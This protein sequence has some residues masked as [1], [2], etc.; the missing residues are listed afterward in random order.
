MKH[1]E[2]LKSFRESLILADSDFGLALVEFCAENDLTDFP[3]GG[4]GQGVAVEDGTVLFRYDMAYDGE[5]L[6]TKSRAEDDSALPSEGYQR[7]GI[8]DRGPIFIL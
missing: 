3:L 4:E 6:F 8:F 2:F 1:Q 7:V 5:V